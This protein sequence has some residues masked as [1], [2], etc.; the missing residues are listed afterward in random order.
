MNC[1]TLEVN[2]I[3]S[4]PTY[5][6]TIRNQN[7]KVIQI[8]HTLSYLRESL[9][10]YIEDDRCK[11]IYNKLENYDS[12]GKFVL[13]LDEREIRYLNSLLKKELEYAKQVQNDERVKE[14]NEVFELLI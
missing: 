9:A 10:N 14:L 7:K 13:D 3:T 11:R 1:T 8:D 12:E 6:N 4:F 2:C 5:N